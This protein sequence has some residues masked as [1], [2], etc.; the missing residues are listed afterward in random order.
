MPAVRAGGKARRPIWDGPNGAW[1]ETVPAHP[2]PDGRMVAEM[3]MVG[4]DARDDGEEQPLRQFGGTP[5]DL[6]E[7]DDWELLE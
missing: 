1:L 3:L 7:A 4:Y 5:Y 6:L 2:L